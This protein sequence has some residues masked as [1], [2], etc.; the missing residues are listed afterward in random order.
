VMGWRRPCARVPPSSLRRC[1]TGRSSLCAV[2]P[3]GS[4]SR[5]TGWGPG[6]RKKTGRETQTGVGL[7]P[8]ETRPMKP[9]P[10]PKPDLPASRASSS[11]L[12]YHGRRCRRAIATVRHVAGNP[13]L[14]FCP[15]VD[16]RINKVDR[17]TTFFPPFQTGTRLP[18]LSIN[19]SPHAPSQLPVRSVVGFLHGWFCRCRIRL[20]P[21]WW[22]TTNRKKEEMKMEPV[23]HAGVLCSHGE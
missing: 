17:C 22:T 15:C 12:F 21:R 7:S 14:L 6:K 23:A 8:R 4:P 16:C 18:P 2:P 13:L 20:R 10:G 9:P 19:P 11:L 1:V 3:A 5:V